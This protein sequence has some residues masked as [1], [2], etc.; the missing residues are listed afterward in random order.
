MK[1]GLST[2]ISVILVLLIAVSTTALVALTLP[3]LTFNIFN[4]ESSFNQSYVESRGCLSIESVD[5]YN[6]EVIIK[7]CGK[8][9]LSNFRLFIDFNEVS[10]SSIPEIEPSEEAVINYLK[11]LSEKNYYNFYAIADLAESPAVKVELPVPIIGVYNTP[12]VMDEN[13]G[14]YCLDSDTP[15]ISSTA[16][17]VAPGV[18][19]AVLDCNGHEIKGNGRYGTYGIYLNGNHNNTIKN[20]IISNF[21]YGIYMANSSDRNTFINISSLKNIEYGIYIEESSGNEL[22]NSN[23]L[24][25]SYYDFYTNFSDPEKCNNVLANV[26][27]TE[28]KPIYYYNNSAVTISGWNNNVSEIVLCNA[29]GS[30]ISNVNLSRS[31]GY[32]LNNGILLVGTNNS[33]INGANVTRCENGVK[34]VNSKNNQI[35]NSDLKF[36]DHS[37][38]YL[39]M[40][41]YNNALFNTNLINNYEYGIQIQSSNYNNLTNVTANLNSVAGIHI[42]S[43]NYNNLTNM[44]VNLN[45]GYG[46]SFEGSGFNLITNSSLLNNSVLDFNIYPWSLSDCNNN[47]TNVNGTEN[48]PI[49]Y[50]NNSY[51]TISG[52]NNNVSEIVLCNA[53]FSSINNVNLSRSS[54][55]PRNNEILLTM[56]DNA[57][58]N[59]VNATNL[60]RGIMLYTSDNNSL[61]NITTYSNEEYGIYL[62]EGADNNKI[63]NSTSSY[64]NEGVHIE[65]WPYGLNPTSNTITNVSVFGN[66][67]YDYWLY[68]SGTNNFTSTNF[69]S[70]RSIYFSDSSSWFNYNNETIGKIWLKTSVSSN[71]EH[72]KRKLI[73]WNNTLMQWNDTSHD[74]TTTVTYNITGLIPNLYY[75]IYDNSVPIPSSPFDSGPNGFIT[76]SISI[77]TNIEHEIKVISFC[78]YHLFS[79]DLASTYVITQSN[80]IYCILDNV[81]LNNQNAINFS[82]GVQ[83]STLYCLGYNNI[84]GNDASNTYGV[85]LTGSNTKNNTIKNCNITNFERGIYFNTGP[86]NNTL[87]NNTVNSN[88]YG[89][90]IFSCSN[91][92][93]INN[94]FNKNTPNYGID[95]ES[96]SN[97]IVTGGSISDNGIDYYFINTNSTN[98]TNTNFTGTRKIF[99]TNSWFNY[100]NETTGNI[101]LNMNVTA[102]S[103]TRKLITWSNTLMMWNET[104]TGS[105]SVTSLYNITGLLINTNYSVYNNSVAISGSPFN[106]SSTGQIN[107]TIYLPASQV[108]NMT[109]ST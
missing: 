15:Q 72:I 10:I 14:Y 9:S 47:M 78:D 81:T 108:R 87:I 89:I 23:L 17:T 1:K 80:K 39:Y 30:S 32:T 8:I 90:F 63:T 2:I 40:G 38:M 66:N 37:G 53:D 16:V 28:N 91:N 69:T 99:S 73:N 26:N 79:P 29:Y 103:I 22:I 94:I 70:L 11:C 74:S 82:S 101:W 3:K 54:A 25:N 95:F 52:W 59:N 51:T 93:L 67:N 97:T 12:S 102:N 46:V 64:N 104:F 45:Y 50:S 71:N 92:I 41:S 68:S 19:N 84:D 85:Y 24:N 57:S 65:H 21:D 107:F 48:K 86:N 33:V 31:S 20:C 49:Y 18:N 56:T 13:D 109:V 100:N 35:N 60:Q 105:G 5:P 62:M 43:S 6:R 96:V 75:N 34:L 58:V 106:S 7:N 27:G 83:N 88:S 4:V 98:F 44:S 36:N 77:P 76:F 42:Y 61:N 55:Y